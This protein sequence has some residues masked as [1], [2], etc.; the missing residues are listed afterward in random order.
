MQ[1]FSKEGMELLDLSRNELV[2][3]CKEA[4]FA[5]AHKGLS[6]ETLIGLLEGI[7]DPS[8]IG[9][10]PID[11]MRKQVMDFIA[12]GGDQLQLTCHGDCRLHSAAKVA[13]CHLILTGEH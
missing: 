3:F 5:V 2:S 8:E 10:N 12:T 7:R 1:P 4:G 13:Q 11:D 9:P 6:E